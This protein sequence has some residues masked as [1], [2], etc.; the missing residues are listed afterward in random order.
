MPLLDRIVLLLLL[1]GPGKATSHLDSSPSLR[2]SADTWTGCYVPAIRQGEKWPASDD[3]AVVVARAPAE[4]WVFHDG[5]LVP[6]HEEGNALVVPLLPPLDK[7][8]H[9][10]QEC[11]PALT[12]LDR[13]SGGARIGSL[14]LTEHASSSFLRELGPGFTLTGVGESGR[15]RYDHGTIHWESRTD[16]PERA[17]CVAGILI[18]DYSHPPVKAKGY[19][20]HA[21]LLAYDRDR[22]KQSY[23][24]QA[25]DPKSQHDV[26]TM[27]GLALVTNPAGRVVGAVVIGYMAEL[28]FAAEPM[29]PEKEL[30]K[31][32]GVG[33]QVLG[34]HVGESAE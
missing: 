18:P 29:P 3:V 13:A 30:M 23:P 14:R 9:G 24:C 20:A 28:L 33:A 25:I 34:S 2:K 10:R 19:A 15:L 21:F 5:Y 17:D 22:S 16:N 11:K 26:E 6:A 12:R 1:L 7:C 27:P 8:P 32:A 31:I 4:Y